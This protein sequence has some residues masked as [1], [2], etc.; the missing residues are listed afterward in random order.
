MSES[1]AAAPASPLALSPQRL[2]RRARVLLLLVLVLLLG[3]AGYVMWARGVFERTQSLVLVS[4][5]SEGVIAG[6]DLTFSGFPIGRVRRTELTDDGRVRILIDVPLKDARWLRTSSIFTLERGMVGDTRIRAF[7]GILS[8]PPLPP[9]AQRDLLRGDAAAELPRLLAS[10]RAILENL[11]L[12]TAANSSLNTTLAQLKLTATRMNG[13]HGVLSGVMGNDA[14]AQKLIT[15][16]ERTNALLASAQT[17]V[18][19]PQGLSDAT[20]ATLAQTQATLK[21]A[22]DS[23]LALRASVQAAVGDAQRTLGRVDAVLEQAQAVGQNV[24]S[25]STDLGTL[26]AEVEA[27]LRRLN[28]LTDDINRKWPFARDTEI[29]LP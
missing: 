3:F 2:Q 10:A 14:D 29:R 12:M 23:L 19:G 28:Q 15:T 13:R 4:D 8:D 1:S 6:M 11:E 27:S 18:F 5:N 22:Q 26:R 17:R 9:N 16:L 24:R 21:T 7:S 20:Q 25:A